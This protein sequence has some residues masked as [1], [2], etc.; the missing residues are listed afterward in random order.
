MAGL[1]EVSNW[2]EDGDDKMDD[3]RTLAVT[4][5][6]SPTASR[7]ERE[8]SEEEKTT[9]ERVTESFCAFISPTRYENDSAPRSFWI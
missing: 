6:Y 5:R 3:R 8:I 4:D 1:E 7:G 9:R 2:S